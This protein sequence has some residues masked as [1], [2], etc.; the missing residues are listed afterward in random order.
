MSTPTPPPWWATDDEHP[1]ACEECGDDD[2][3]PGMR[4]CTD[5]LER[6]DG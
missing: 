6:L 4:Y 1:G 3:M 2:P 5:C